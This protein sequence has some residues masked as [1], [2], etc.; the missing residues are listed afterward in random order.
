MI[1]AK[2]NSETGIAEMELSGLG[3]E[4]FVDMCM[5]TSAMHNRLSQDSEDLAREMMLA[6][7]EYITDLAT[8]EIINESSAESIVIDPNFEDFIKGLQ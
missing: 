2:L 7:A 3:E 4:L 6:L 1:N 8:G 5:F